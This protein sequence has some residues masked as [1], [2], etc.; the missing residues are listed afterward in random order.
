MQANAAASAS[1]D[2]SERLVCAVLA[3]Q[4]AVIRDRFDNTEAFDILWQTADLLE[5]LATLVEE[6]GRRCPEPDANLDEQCASAITA[7][8]EAR[9]A[10]DSLAFNQSQQRDIARQMADC[11]ATALARLAADQTQAAGR[12][13][14]PEDLAALYVCDMQREIHEIVASRFGLG[15]ASPAPSAGHGEAGAGK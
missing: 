10:L 9:A 1:A 5:R 15:T 14:S 12:R 11:V 7:Q 8:A 3:A 4:V 2:A 13:L 6:L